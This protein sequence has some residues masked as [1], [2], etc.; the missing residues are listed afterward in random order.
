MTWRNSWDTGE[1][2][3]RYGRMGWDVMVWS[4]NG[5]WQEWDGIGWD[6]EGKSMEVDV[7]MRGNG[8]SILTPLFD[9]RADTGRTHVR[10]DSISVEYPPVVAQ[11]GDL[12]IYRIHFMTLPYE[13]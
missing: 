11:K 1:D 6:I 5:S 12:M 7:D 4:G 13:S 9:D 8:E 10:N 3:V 2:G